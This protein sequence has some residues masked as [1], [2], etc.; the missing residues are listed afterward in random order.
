MRAMTHRALAVM[1]CATLLNGL[2]ACGASSASQS[3]TPTTA[4][5]GCSVATTSALPGVDISRLTGRIV[6]S[7]GPPHDE[8]VYVMG[9]NGVG[10][11]QLT[12]NPG[13]EF[14]PSWSPDGRQIVYRDSRRGNNSD[15]EIYVMNADGSGQRNL[16]NHPI[17]DWGP[18]WSPD[19]A[20]IAFNSG[21]SGDNMSIYLMNPDGSGVQRLTTIEGE[22]PAWSPDGKR[23]AF[24]SQ[25]PGAFGN[26]P[27][28]DIMVMQ[29]N[30]S[31]VTPLTTYTGVDEGTAWSP[32]GT[33]I[34]FQSARCDTGPSAGGGPM[35]DI[36]VM[37]A[38][39][40]GQTRLTSGGG[41][42]PAWSPDGTKLV[43]QGICGGIGLCVMN[44]DGSGLT[45]LLSGEEWNFPSWI[46]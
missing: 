34:T 36:F 42:R 12:K 7:G 11:T 10:L 45:Q 37:S 22:Y 2:L 4:S 8:D 6:L 39:G 13:S 19:G 16:S 31:G 15:D 25:Q 40:S 33:R 35:E 14:D 44:A 1:F 23:I 28:Y 18:A 26:N 9:A 32:D 21:R 38:D 30:G 29:A 46:P 43:F 24:E 5:S 27:N 17:N 41:Y 3:P 20:K